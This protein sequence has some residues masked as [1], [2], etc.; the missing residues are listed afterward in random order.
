MCPKGNDPLTKTTALSAQSRNYYTSMSDIGVAELEKPEVQTIV[1]SPVRTLPSNS[2]AFDAIGGHF[3]LTYT[4]MY[5]QGWTTRPIRVKS[6]V[7]TAATADIADGATGQS[8]ISNEEGVFGMFQD[9]DNILVEY[10]SGLPQSHVVKV[11]EH[12]AG[13]QGLLVQPRITAV[14]DGAL[15]LTLIN[16]DC[17]EI[18]VTRALTELPNQVIPS[19]T[20]DETITTQEN[21]FRV[22]FSDSAN[23][24]D[25]AM[26]SCK[27]DACNSDG[28]QPRK[29]AMRAQ[30]TVDNGAA[31]TFNAGN[32]QLTFASTK[33]TDTMVFPGDH[34]AYGH[35]TS[36]Y[37][38][39][40]VT[41]TAEVLSMSGTVA[42]LVDRTISL[43]DSTAGH[44]SHA[45][46]NLNDRDKRSALSIT[47]ACADGAGAICTIAAN[48][49]F[50]TANNDGT[51][52][53]VGDV[54]LVTSL[55]PAGTDKSPN[56]GLH[57]VTATAS[58][59]LTLSRVDG[60]AITVVSDGDQ[61][62]TIVITRVSTFPCSVVE[63]RKGTAESMECSGRGTCDGST[64][65]CE[66]FEGYT[67]DDCSMQTVLV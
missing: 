66:C 32:F 59:V 42:T 39:T 55:P 25:Q 51:R 1:L 34:L 45:L 18:G 5:G 47:H 63:T 49:Q 43:A 4:D 36:H 19:V 24:G 46:V 8:I 9:H 61:Y 27:V 54:V 29:D 15:T 20:V 7:V 65:Q 35:V 48:G 22:T 56:E 41:H 16:Q 52:Y 12:G 64:G 13:F 3:S 57:R 2:H 44:I 26:L 31:V 17:G 37:S 14:T 10:T 6:K 21:V 11:I 50:V 33:L 38:S 62:G 58:A 28:C 53:S 23:A 40:K 30:L 60:G 67:S